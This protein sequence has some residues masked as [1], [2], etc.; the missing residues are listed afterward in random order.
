MMAV[1]EVAAFDKKQVQA[2]A[3]HLANGDLADSP[4]KGVKVNNWSEPGPA[5]FDFRSKHY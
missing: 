5:A 4:Q 1:D 2:E 3:R